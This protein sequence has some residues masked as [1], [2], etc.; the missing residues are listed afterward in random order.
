MLSPSVAVETR[1]TAD[2]LLEDLRE[3]F[4]A[5]PVL[6]Q[7]NLDDPERFQQGL[8]MYAEG[9]RGAAGARVTDDD[10][11]LLLLREP[12]TADAWD[13]PGGANDPGEGLRETARREVWE[14]A[15]VE[16]ELTGVWVAVHKRFVNRVEPQQRGYML[17]VIFEA[18][19][20]GGEAGLYPE[21]WD[22]FD[23]DDPDE[24]ILDVEWFAEPPENALGVVTD[25]YAWGEEDL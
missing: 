8:E 18:D 24:Q 20:T 6:R 2:G 1:T 3:E 14:E 21:R 15:G 23:D 13:L 16:C 22:T 10:G 19:Y 25:P 4:G 9:F 5:F 7:T 11:R 17:E 12:R